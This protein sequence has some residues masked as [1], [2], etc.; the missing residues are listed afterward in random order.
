MSTGQLS[1]RRRYREK[2]DWCVENKICTQCKSNP[3]KEGMTRCTECSN[4]EKERKAATSKC[5]YFKRNGLIKK[6]PS[7]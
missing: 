1:A 7:V 5:K 2:Y 6:A 3:A 4:K